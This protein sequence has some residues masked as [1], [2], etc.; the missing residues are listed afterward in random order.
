MGYF[1]DYDAGR[2]NPYELPGSG[3]TN[4][5][6]QQGQFDEQKRI[7]EGNKLPGPPTPG[8]GVATGPTYT[9]PPHPG[10][11]KSMIAAVLLPLM[12]G[13]IGLFYASWKAALVLIA[14]LVVVPMATGTADDGALMYVTLAG[15]IV[16]SV[17]WSVAAIWRYNNNVRKRLREMGL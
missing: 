10:S 9:G 7:L 4:F 13:P 15:S 3:P 12:L 6:F 17:V 1:N 14:L 8:G 2:R 16:V 11:P 5:A